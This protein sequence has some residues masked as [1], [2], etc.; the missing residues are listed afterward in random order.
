[1]D[2]DLSFFLL[3]GSLAGLGGGLWL[4]VQGFGAHRSATRLADTATSMI[5]SLAVGE[6][7][8]SGVVV[9][10]ELTLLSPLQSETCV[11]Y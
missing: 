3:A 4:L 6:V 11:Y 7:R 2:S 1:M 5:S 9:P 8:I 10:A